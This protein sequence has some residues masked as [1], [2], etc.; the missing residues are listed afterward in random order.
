MNLLKILFLLAPLLWVVPGRSQSFQKVWDQ[1]I[2]E[3]RS[4][5]PAACI[6]RSDGSLVLLTSSASD[7]GIWKSCFNRDPSQ[8]S[9][10]FWLVCIDSYGNKRWDR[11]YGSSSGDRARSMIALADGGFLLGGESDGGIGLDKSDSCRGFNDY[12]II[13]VDSV[14]NKIWDKTVGG[15]GTDL[16][17]SMVLMDDGS[18]WIA[19]TSLSD[20]GADKSKANLGLFDCWLVHLDS[21]GTL[22]HENSIGSSGSDH[23]QKILSVSNGGLLLAAHSDGPANFDKSEPSKGLYDYWLLKLDS[24]GRPVWDRVYGGSA[25]DWLLDACRG[26]SKGFI[27]GGS[28]FSPQGLDKS[29]ASRG[30]DDY[31]LVC[32]DSAGNKRWDATYGGINFDELNSL[33]Q[34]R[35]DRYLLG[36]ESY[37]PIG[38]EKT[39][40]NLGTEQ[41]WMLE[42][43]S[44]GAVIF[45]KT[46]FTWGHDE[47]GRAMKLR[48]DCYLGFISSSTDTG[49]YKSQFS[50]GLTD[51]WMAKLCPGTTATE[52]EPDHSASLRVFPNP[53]HDYL[54]LEAT[55]PGEF[56][57]YNQWSQLIHRG[58]I[59]KAGKY[60]IHLE[61]QASGLLMLEWIGKHRRSIL[62][63]VVL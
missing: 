57:I 60:E 5:S 56:R 47:L 20:S 21:S 40:D 19:G 30:F 33:Q 6:E 11:C 41:I 25:T 2:G 63:L 55:E 8:Q 37:S 3:N 34:I 16:L 62:R 29:Q 43:D 22:L 53:F 13:R 23:P 36:G 44:S 18:Y 26:P 12:W 14:G 10:D 58:R 35:E 46:F 48:D 1:T 45:D 59:E 24:I 61:N 9:V 50:R 32:V 15:P 28:S 51:V 39:E 52:Q 4:E 17:T 38:F 49:G 42:I 54:N 7:T 31:W 27:L